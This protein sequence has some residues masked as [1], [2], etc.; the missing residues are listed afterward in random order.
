MDIA[1]LEALVA[2]AETGSFSRASEQLFITQPAISKR[3]ATLEAE[4]G[5]TLVDRLGRN[6]RLTEAGETLLVS[7]KRILAD[8]ATSREQVQTLSHEI[9]GKLSFATS[10][11]IGIHRL[12][13]VLKAFTQQY[14]NVELDLMFMDSEKA[15]DLV[16]DGS[17]ELAVV[18]L[19][20]KAADNLVTDLIW[21]DPLWIV[22]A[23]DHPLLGL[24]KPTPKDLS[25]HA[26]VLPAKG[27]VTRE[28]VLEA[29]EPQDISIKTTLETNY[30]ET[31]KMM[32]SVGLG[33]S[34]LP[35]SMVDS[36]IS[37]VNVKALNMHRELGSVQ[38]KDRTLGRAASALLKLLENDQQ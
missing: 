14:P 18:T 22:C 37:V 21:D 11:H 8:L 3:I 28:I 26:A 36:T 9:S 34:V 16:S 5:V 12:P 38:L 31:I 25:K 19:P 33:W 20:Q 10:H 13:A 7:A 6:T 1:S 4:L 35:L 15:C 32:V 2:I 27:T 24:S 30:L 17:I 23:K 29:L